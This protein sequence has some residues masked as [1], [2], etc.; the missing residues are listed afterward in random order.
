MLMTVEDHGGPKQLTRVRVWPRLSPIGT[1]TALLLG[2]VSAAALV[3]GAVG[4]A[5]A[6]LA[7]GSAVILRSFWESGCAAR[8]VETAISE[9][10]GVRIT[11]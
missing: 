9:L 8:K 2:L 10:E 6:F 3:D 11:T 4:A 5:T 7:L 1:A